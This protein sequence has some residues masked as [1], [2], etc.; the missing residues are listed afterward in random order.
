MVGT[1]LGLI[2]YFCLRRLFL[3]SLANVFR[4]HVNFSFQVWQARS[5]CKVSMPSRNHLHS[6]NNSHTST[7][8]HV[9][10]YCACT[11]CTFYCTTCTSL[12][13]CYTHV[14]TCSTCISMYM[15]MYI[16]HVYSRTTLSWIEPKAFVQV[17]SSEGLWREVMVGTFRGIH[18]TLVDVCYLG[19]LV[20][21]RFHC[22]ITYTMCM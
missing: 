1:S 20:K 15:Y 5:A 4:C 6:N 21:T 7:N 19:L 13:M 10:L 18:Y 3:W 12:V 14:R 2:T 8:V 11:T 16:V 17:S 22:I 9:S